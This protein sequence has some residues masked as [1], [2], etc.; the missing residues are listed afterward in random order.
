MSVRACCGRIQRSPQY[1]S[2]TI[3]PDAP[4][5]PHTPNLG[6]S[7]RSREFLMGLG[8]RLR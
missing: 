4:S 1:L 6:L 8:E 5:E 3:H 2:P 7:C